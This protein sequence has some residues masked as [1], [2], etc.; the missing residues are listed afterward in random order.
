ML[1]AFI[2][3]LAVVS[4]AIQ[5]AD[6][7]P[8]RALL[9]AG[10]CCHD[11]A[12]QQ[13]ILSRGIQAR[14]NVQVDVIWTDDKSVTPPLP[15]YDKTDWAAGYDIVIHDECA[16]GVKDPALL[17][18]ILDVHKTVPAVHLHCAMHS[19]R[20]G[21]DEWFRHL[22]IQSASHGPQEPI[23]ISYIDKSHPITQTLLDWT[24]IKEELYNNLNLFGAHPLAMGKQSVKQKDGTAKEVEYIVAWINEKQGARSFS[25][26]IGH[27]SETVADGRYLDLVTRGLLWACGKLD[28]DHLTP[29]KGQNK[30]SF[31][32]ANPPAP[33]PAAVAPPIP[34]K[35]ATLV[36]AT[37]SS[38]ET[39]KNNFAWRAVD[40]DEN[41][42]WCASDG[43]YPQWL[44][45]EL[46]KP[47]ALNGIFLSWE[48]NGV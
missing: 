11:Y 34:A 3:C 46:E 14:A 15:I 16:A 12:K 30:V 22:G 40:N 43:S 7:K 48:N 10:G 31:V 37:A 44:Q 47:Q 23:A 20:T 17:K 45:L 35:D 13:E 25:T 9:I 21:T 32:K 1:R 36:S 39:G 33:Q 29:F 42:R 28:A 2:L 26:T 8:L 24:T 41:T 5:A 4:S 18:R 19:F 6:H 27:N 38:E